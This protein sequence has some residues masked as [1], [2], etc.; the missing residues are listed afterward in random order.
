MKRIN[1]SNY[2]YILL[3][4]R[5]ASK[6]ILREH[7]YMWLLNHKLAK[8]TEAEVQTPIPGPQRE[9]GFVG[10][11]ANT[12]FLPLSKSADVVSSAANECF[13]EKALRSSPV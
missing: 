12:V 8:T 4:H 3:N 13:K 10:G 6:I 1:I 7:E 2:K 9:F 5:S 11:K